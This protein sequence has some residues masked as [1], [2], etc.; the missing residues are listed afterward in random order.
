[1]RS[2]ETP[3]SLAHKL[4]PQLSVPR[5][6]GDRTVS[7]SDLIRN[8]GAHGA[9]REEPSSTQKAGSALRATAAFLGLA[10]NSVCSWYGV[11]MKWVSAQSSGLR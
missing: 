8:S 7:L 6:S 2:W 1:M 9:R 10:R 5:S 11:A 3:N 4:S